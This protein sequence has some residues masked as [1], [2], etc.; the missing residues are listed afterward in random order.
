MRVSRHQNVRG[1]QQAC[2][3]PDQACRAMA[4]WGGVSHRLISVLT[5]Q[6][7]ACSWWHT[8]QSWRLGASCCTAMCRPARPSGLQS[9][10]CW[11]TTIA[12]CWGCSPRRSALRLQPSWLLMCTAPVAAP[13]GTRR[14][15]R[16]STSLT[17]L[18]LPLCLRQIRPVD[19]RLQTLPLH[20]FRRPLC[21]VVVGQAWRQ[22]GGA[23]GRRAPGRRLRQDLRV[24][25]PGHDRCICPGALSPTA[26]TCCLPALEAAL[27]TPMLQC[28]NAECIVP[29]L[30]DSFSQRATIVP[31]AATA[32]RLCC[33]CRAKRS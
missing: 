21:Q 6:M 18:P 10:T 9:P 7:L 17:L 29:Q 33:Y 2:T 19:T 30:A 12:C 5:L 20:S 25:V 11:T 16:F 3:S 4:V 14:V 24:E 13:P 27:P 8:T 26:T 32:C 1:P 22:L 15:Y 23:A 28:H 31:A